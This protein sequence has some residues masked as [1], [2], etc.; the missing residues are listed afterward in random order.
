[1]D[2]EIRFYAFRSTKSKFLVRAV[3]GIA[4]F[5]T[6]LRGATPYGQIPSAAPRA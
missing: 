6:R 5:E 4:R 3:H 2:Q 1:M